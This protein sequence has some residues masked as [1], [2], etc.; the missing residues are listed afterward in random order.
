MTT[1]DRRSFLQASLGGLAGLA[2]VPLLT[3]LEG[4]Q[5]LPVR[6]AAEKVAALPSTK[7]G[8]RISVVTGA[9]GNV[10][11]LSS[12][13]GIVLVDSGSSGLAAA[14]RASLAGAHVSTLIDTHYHADQT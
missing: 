12:S 2:S 8:D 4:C 11:A 5:Q 10:V 6:P 14:V 3:G 13:E 7:L 1:T 9:P